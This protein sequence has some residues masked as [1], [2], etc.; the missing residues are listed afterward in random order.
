VPSVEVREE[1]SCRY[2]AASVRDA[3]A[4]LEQIHVGV[5]MTAVAL[6]S[7]DPCLERKN[8][9]PQHRHPVRLAFPILMLLDLQ[10]SVRLMIALDDCLIRTASREGLGHTM[11]YCGSDTRMFLNGTST[12]PVCVS[13]RGQDSLM[14]SASTDHGS[15]AGHLTNA[16]ADKGS[17][18]LFAAAPQT[19]I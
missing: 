19:L 1:R 16:E 5:G 9:C 18:E 13:F 17:I 14:I 12:F 4:Y 2:P 10:P 11:V 8:R 6:P 7:S 3:I 15:R